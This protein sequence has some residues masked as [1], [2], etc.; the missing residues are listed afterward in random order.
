MFGW[1]EA[2]LISVLNGFALGSLLFLL[3]LGLSLVFGM[4]NVLNLA[5]G[6]LYLAGAY[7]AYSLL[8][9]TGGIGAFAVVLLLAIVVGVIAGAVLSFMTEPLKNRGYLY[10]ALLTLGVGLVLAESLYILF[11]QDVYGVA[12]PPELS[13]TVTVAGQFYPAYRLALIA[14]GGVLA[15]VLYWVME[16]TSVGA[17]IRATVA[18]RQMVQAMGIRAR[19]ILFS[20]FAAGGA[21]A[22]T[23]GVLGA[24]LY[25]ARPGLDGRILVLALV[26]V[27]IGG[28]GSV[29]GALIGAMII[30]QVE[31]L[32]RVLLPQFS[33]FLLFG[34]MAMILI[35]RPRGLLGDVTRSEE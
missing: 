33:S 14:V 3:A 32:G 4:M 24:P 9:N 28:M 8:G 10:Q 12:P 22:T 34:A 17:L 23:A 31:S 13:T 19:W 2:N 27:V 5:H 15:A 6:A 29:S 25:G 7:L 1:L 16:K 26:I 35:L 30:G 11:G 21:L 18:D 20:V